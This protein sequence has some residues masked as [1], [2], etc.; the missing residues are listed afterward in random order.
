MKNRSV[1]LLVL[2]LLLPSLTLSCS[3]PIVY[4]EYGVPVSLYGRGYLL[5]N[6][7]KYDT[8]LTF[9]HYNL[10]VKNTNN[11]SLT[12]YLIPS[13]QLLSYVY[14]GEITLA[15]RETR[16]M[17]LYV[18][19][20][21]FDKLGEMRV[22]GYCEDGMPIPEGVMNVYIDGRDIED[23]PSCR[24]TVTSCGIWP[25]C[26][27][28]SGWDGCYGGYYRR[29]YCA[30]NTI[31]YNTMCSD[32]CCKQHVGDDGY[33]SGGRCVDPLPNCEDECSFEDLRCIENNVYSC[34]VGEDG[35]Y[36]LIL[37]EECESCINGKCI[38]KG[39]IKV[40]Y[41]CRNEKCSDGI[42][43]DTIGWLSS[44]GHFVV[45]K[46]YKSWSLEELNDYDVMI[47]SDETLACKVKRSVAYESH[48]EGKPFLEIADYPRV[49]AGYAFSYV[50]SPSGSIAK[51][52]ELYVTVED[53]ITESLS[54]KVQ[55]FS[56]E[57][58]MVVLHDHHLTKGVIDIA[59][60][61]SD[62]MRTTFFKVESGSRRYAYVGWFYRAKS[63]DLT[64]SGKTL[65]E[66]TILWLICGDTC[67][68]NTNGDLTENKPPVALLNV[69]PN[70]AYI[71]ATI[72]LDASESYDPDGDELTFLYDFDDGNGYGWTPDEK[73]VHVFLEEGTYNVS[74]IVN[75]GTVN[76]TVVVSVVVLPEKRK[77]ALICK[78]D[79]CDG[80]TDTMIKGFLEKYGYEVHGKQESKWTDRELKDYTFIVC[81]SDCNI[82]RRGAV[83]ENHINKGLSFLEIPHD[84][85]V[86][87]GYKFGYVSNY[88]CTR[89]RSDKLTFV[90]KDPITL[91]ISETVFEEE[92]TMVGLPVRDLKPDVVNLA[93]IRR[94]VSGMFKVDANG[95]RGRYAYVGWL[96]RAD[97]NDLTDDGEEL[98]L[99]IVRW[100]ES[101]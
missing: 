36:R 10:T 99:R 9:I 3:N 22:E 56:K 92:E 41:F 1:G 39:K 7:S 2:F 97:V 88:K 101:G 73:V 13:A 65:L 23:P 66:N 4:N 77:V 60:V 54:K 74:L 81:S 30:G 64:E 62:R 16:S 72:E 100:V 6:A 86:N 40:A 82:R 45:G 35:C 75:D 14:G 47:C 37:Q 57:K 24:N 50:K 61:E 25:N 93:N 44:M 5:I 31:R 87:A 70:P 80:K 59:D 67:S 49:Q 69:K 52:D 28:I 90:N 18:Y 85:Y 78:R 58:K 42:E 27:D 51:G 76:S 43:S 55:I 53:V 17:N 94:G 46:S 19:I 71:G 12:L 83:F 96:Y 20:N 79:S 29:Y 38:D 98:L 21:G 95:K 11:E 26:I 32:Y 34:E 33:C 63:N 8:S 91:S 89:T 48:N 15:P 68:T 84:R